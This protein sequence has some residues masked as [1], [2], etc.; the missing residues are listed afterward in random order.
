MRRLAGS[1]S[2]YL[3]KITYCAAYRL[4]REVFCERTHEAVRLSSEHYRRPV[5]RHEQ[6]SRSPAANK[7]K[8]D[9][10]RLLW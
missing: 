4:P 8:T 10:P 7:L 2:T 5:R 1:A 6:M 9:K 3:A